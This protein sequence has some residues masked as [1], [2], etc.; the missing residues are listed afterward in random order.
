[1]FFW[2]SLI[3]LIMFDHQSPNGQQVRALT[4]YIYIYKDIAG[5]DPLVSDLLLVKMGSSRGRRL[6]LGWLVFPNLGSSE[7]IM[8]KSGW[9]VKSRLTFD[10]SFPKCRSE[11]NSIMAQQY[12][13]R[14]LLTPAALH[15]TLQLWRDPPSSVLGWVCVNLHLHHLG[16]LS[17]TLEKCVRPGELQERGLPFAPPSLEISHGTARSPKPGGTQSERKPQ[18]ASSQW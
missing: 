4:V 13:N 14:F 1:M 16:P 2:F 15:V 17:S 8:A 11:M 18:D 7:T 12:A 5:H 6:P 3:G 10:R 9:V